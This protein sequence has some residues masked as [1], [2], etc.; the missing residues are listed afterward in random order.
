MEFVGVLDLIEL[1]PECEEDE[2][3][4]EIK[5]SLRPMERRAKL[6]PADKDLA[7]IRCSRIRKRARRVR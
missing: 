4:Y 7:A 1:D 6:L 2:V 3:W 5:T